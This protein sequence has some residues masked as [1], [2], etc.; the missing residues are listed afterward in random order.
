MQAYQ[1]IRS[2]IGP[3]WLAQVPIQIPFPVRVFPQVVNDV[4]E[5]AHPD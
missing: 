2:V 1:D 3:I 4:A 5:P